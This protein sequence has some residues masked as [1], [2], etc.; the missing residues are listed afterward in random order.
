MNWLTWF[1]PREQVAHGARPRV[2]RTA[3][4]V[5][6]SS[7]FF[8]LVGLAMVG[9]WGFW[10]T[11]TAI[12]QHQQRQK[13]E[14][15]AAEFRATSPAAELPTGQPLTPD[16]AVPAPPPRP[17]DVLGTIE[18]PSSGISA[19]VAEGVDDGTLRVAVGHVP[20][21]GLPGSTRN[22]GLAGHRD[23]FFRGLGKI[24]SGDRIILRTV[25]G[26]FTYEVAWHKIVKPHETWVLADEEHPALTLVT[27]YPFGYVGNAPKRYI[28]RARLVEES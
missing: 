19:V 5:R 4:A 14:Q 2:Q 1:I 3:G 23:S 16:P 28:V 26:T 18:H 12:Y 11:Y 13:F 9:V 7:N 10:Q 24:E 20:T 21:T 17:G 8:L 22:V 25:Q 6:W 15:L 27:C